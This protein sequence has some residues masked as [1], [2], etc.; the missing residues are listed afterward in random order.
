MIRKTNKVY[1]HD[2]TELLKQRSQATDTTD[3]DNNIMSLALDYVM[4]QVYQTQKYK[5]VNNK[6]QAVSDAVLKVWKNIDKIDYKV[7]PWSYFLCIIN[8][9]ILDV[10]RKDKRYYNALKRYENFK[11]EGIKK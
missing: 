9:A 6:Q 1:K 2:L 4:Y 8:S 7:N 5:H 11:S 3:T 10:V